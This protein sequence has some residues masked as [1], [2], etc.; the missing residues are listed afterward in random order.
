MASF[1]ILMQNFYKL[2][3][4]KREKMTV[5]VTQLERALTAVEQEF[6]MMLSM[7]EVQNHLRDHLFH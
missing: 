7:N 6:P 1:N 4:E 3:Q 2:Q 5:Y